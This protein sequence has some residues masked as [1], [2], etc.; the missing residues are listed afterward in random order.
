MNGARHSLPY[1]LLQGHR[2]QEYELVCMSDSDDFG[3]IYLGFDRNP[4]KAG[5]APH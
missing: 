3:M 1:A 5:I 2:S 4:D